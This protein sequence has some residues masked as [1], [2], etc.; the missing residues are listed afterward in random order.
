M[1]MRASSERGTRN[2]VPLP[3]PL[4]GRP[5]SVWPSPIS[6]P[7]SALRPARMSGSLRTATLLTLILSACTPP[8]TLAPV[9]SGAAASIQAGA[10][11]YRWSPAAA[12]PIRLY[13]QQRSDLPG[14]TPAH[15]AMVDRAVR[16]WSAG[17]AVDVVRTGY[18]GGA[19]IRL[20][21]TSGLPAQ[22]P[23]V[24]ML[25]LDR[26]GEMV[27]A[28]IWVNVTAPAIAGV[29][30]EDVLY[31]VI[32][33]EVGHALGMPHVAQ[34]DNLMYPILGAYSVTRADLDALRTVATTGSLPRGAGGRALPEAAVVVGG[35]GPR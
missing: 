34:K 31:A 1:R 13:V 17:G 30:A 6:G 8:A 12:Q 10:R 26:R 25:K 16:A 9:E 35:A 23:G 20:R 21:W 29:S 15:R 28:D 33:H 22:H 7:V 5:G 27:Q 2:L 11:A 3:R 14:F 19:S 18:A 4:P 32:A 24:T